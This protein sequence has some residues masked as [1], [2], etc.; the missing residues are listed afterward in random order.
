[1]AGL[2]APIDALPFKLA[3]ANAPILVILAVITPVIARFG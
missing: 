2:S 3:L 1:M